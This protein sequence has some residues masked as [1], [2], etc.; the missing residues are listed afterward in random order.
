MYINVELDENKSYFDEFCTVDLFVGLCKHD[1]L[2]MCCRHHFKAQ[3]NIFML[4]VTIP[5]KMPSVTL[6]RDEREI[7]EI[8]VMYIHI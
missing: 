4:A 7:K 2:M 1:V 5:T 6:L 8:D 3:I